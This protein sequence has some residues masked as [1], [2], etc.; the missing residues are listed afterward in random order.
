VKADN[1]EIV[2]DTTIG[3]YFPSGVQTGLMSCYLTVPIS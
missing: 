3:L 1:G 2:V